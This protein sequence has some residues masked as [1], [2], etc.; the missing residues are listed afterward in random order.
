[1]NVPPKDKTNCFF[2]QKKGAV[3][4]EVLLAI[5][6]MSVGL[7]FII[8]SFVSSLRA[9]IYTSGYSTAIILLEN[10][11]YEYRQSNVIKEDI[12]EEGIFEK[13]YDK[14]RYRIESK[15]ITEEGSRKDLNEM[16][17]RVSWSS[18]K[19]ENNVSVTTYI[20]SPPT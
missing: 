18:G 12:K 9:N 2:S 7:T 16:T 15:K 6:I 4:I 5:T 1:M 13:P 8:Q 20:F 3:I 14:F 19:R 17:L 10:K 11:M